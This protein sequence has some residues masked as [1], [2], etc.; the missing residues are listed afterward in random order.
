MLDH[1]LGKPSPSW[2][3]TQVFLVVLFWLTRLVRGDRNGPRVF[4][5]R[6]A[7]RALSLS[8]PPREL[9]LTRK[10]INLTPPVAKYT[11]YQIVLATLTALYTIR[12]LDYI[13]N[14]G[15]QC[16]LLGFVEVTQDLMDSAHYSA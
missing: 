1:I 9:P 8:S 13:L 6:K 5:L 3:R 7:S 16:S 12:H 4:W 11:P 14:L 15:C 10:S 2:K